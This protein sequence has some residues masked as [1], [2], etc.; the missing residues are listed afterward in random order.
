MLIHQ[1]DHCERT[2]L[3]YQVVKIRMPAIEGHTRKC[4]AIF[5]FTLFVIQC[6]MF[7]YIKFLSNNFSKKKY[8]QNEHN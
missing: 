1:S 5:L 7:F 6:I 3:K 2:C 8:I 4:N